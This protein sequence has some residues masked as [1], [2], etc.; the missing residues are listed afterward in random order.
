[1]TEWGK[2]ISPILSRW[3]QRREGRLTGEILHAQERTQCRLQ[4]GSMAN[5]TLRSVSILW[6]PSL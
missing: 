1:M 2:L 4:G 5:T 3:S 6:P